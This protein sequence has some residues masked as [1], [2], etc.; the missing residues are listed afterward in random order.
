VLILCSW[1]HQQRVV[2]G[3]SGGDGQGQVHG[4]QLLHAALVTGT[5]PL[6][7]LV[8]PLLF[9]LVQSLRDAVWQ[10]AKKSLGHRKRTQPSTL[11]GGLAFAVASHGF[12]IQEHV[13]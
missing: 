12:L 7:L 11:L 9:H 2:E 5:Q 10:A 3:S 6:L 13:G 1:S 4:G 8:P